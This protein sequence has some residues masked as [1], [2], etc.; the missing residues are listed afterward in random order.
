MPS[1]RLPAPVLIR[2][3]KTGEITNVTTPVELAIRKS[4]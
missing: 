1:S 3:I 2:Y 4:A